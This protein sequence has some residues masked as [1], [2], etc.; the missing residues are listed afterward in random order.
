MK[1]QSANALFHKKTL[2][3]AI[4]HFSFP[5]D[6]DERR[7]RIAR[8]IHAL[9]SGSLDE[10]KETSLHGQFLADI[11]QHVL[12][13][14]G[15]I[16]GEGQAWE[17]HPERTIAAGGGTADGAL[18]WFHGASADNAI[19]LSGRVVAPI[20]LKG[21]RTDLDYRPAAGRR[22][23]AVEQGWHYANYTPD[24]KWIIVSNYREIRLYQTTKTPA[25]YEQFLLTDLEAPEE[26]RRFYYLLCRQ[27]F[28]PDPDGI[29]TIDRLL[30]RSSEAQEQIT[31]ELYTE[32]SQ[33][34]AEL[35]DHF[36]TTGPPLVSSGRIRATGPSG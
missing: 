24:C 28:L 25:Y 29:S 35:V 26:L 8:W 20:E 36:L 18:G 5:P 14:R 3:T 34:R 23:S 11:F 1:P 31:A 4:A 13:Y 9:R 17:L 33:I 22:E 15:I 27:N 2:E 16:D 7:V 21:A 32:Y 19:P 10:I 6:L 30:A 12:G